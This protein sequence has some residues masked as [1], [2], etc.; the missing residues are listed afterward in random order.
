MSMDQMKSLLVNFDLKT[1]LSPDRPSI[2]RRLSAMAGMFSD[3]IQYAAA[4]AR[5]DALI[6]EF[7]DLGMPEREGDIAFGTSITYPG[8]VGDE[9][10]MTKGHFHTILDTGEMYYC[11]RGQGMMLMEN[12]EGDW[13]AQPLKAGASV[14]VPPRY[15]HRSINVS[16]GEPLVTF[17]AFRADAGHDYGTIES[18]GFRMLVKDKAGSPEIV[19]NPKWKEA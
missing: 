5:E 14:Y 9:Y 7:Y 6:Y 19:D 18:K 1:G 13:E 11:L 17:F 2:Q 10:Y 12:P 15:A 3:D 4:L 16:S 8:T